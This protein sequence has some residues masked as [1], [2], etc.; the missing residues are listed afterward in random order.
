MLTCHLTVKLVILLASLLLTD[1]LP[2]LLSVC[3]AH[4]TTNMIIC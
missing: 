3:Q 2:G 4:Y 1:L